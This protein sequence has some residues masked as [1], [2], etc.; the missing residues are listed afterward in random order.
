M[1]I[2]EDFDA[3][4]HGLPH[5]DEAPHAISEPGCYSSIPMAAY[6]AD[7]C[8]QPSLSPSVAHILATKSPR[9]AWH[10]HHRLG[11]GVRVSTPATITGSFI[12]ELL[13]EDGKRVEVVDA[14]DFKTKAARMQR[15]AALASGLIPMVRSKYDEARRVVDAIRDGIVECG[16]HWWTVPGAMVEHTLVWEEYAERY[17]TTANGGT[18][19][20]CR[21]DVI[22]RDGPDILVVDIKTTQDAAPDAA[23]GS[24]TEYGYDIQHEANVRACEKL[25]PESVGRV[26]VVYLFCELE[27]PYVVSPIMADGAMRELGAKRWERSLGIWSRCLAEDS[28]PAYGTAPIAVTPR[29]WLM[30]REEM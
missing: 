21:P 26:R 17:P 30:Q 7:P 9:H 22:F 5:E 15:D 18:L 2:E 14:P 13:L 27:P 16:L 28:W 8:V 20:R 24:M 4:V 1:T 19:C 23:A 11:A 10:A 6:V 29:A 12:H 25:W 3:A